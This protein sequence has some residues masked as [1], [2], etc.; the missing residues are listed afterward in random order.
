M[1]T[2]LQGRI[3]GCHNEGTV[4][5]TANV[6]IVAILETLNIMLSTTFG[7]TCCTLVTLGTK[8]IYD[9][10]CHINKRFY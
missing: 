7:N 4:L 8:Y 6:A 3:T 5:I 1:N 10:N 9:K 2:T